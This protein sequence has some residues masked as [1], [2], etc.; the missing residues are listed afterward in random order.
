MRRRCQT[1]LR[2]A[3]AA[4]DA[5][6]EAF[7]NLI[8]YGGEY[9]NAEAK[10]PWLYRVCDRV[11]FAHLHRQ[12]RYVVTDGGEPPES[13]APTV[14][15]EA[16]SEVLSL[17][18]A[19]PPRDRELA[20]MAYVEGR[21]QGEIGQLTGWSRQTINKRLRAIRE[22]AAAHFGRAQS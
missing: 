18:Y 5:L 6:Q 19:L 21:S 20:V 9:R 15:H 4:D 14:P 7:I 11:C 16:R 17:L 8:R 10:L 3:S 13:S 2:S 12:K 1:L 22:R